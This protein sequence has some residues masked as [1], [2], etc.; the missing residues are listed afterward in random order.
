MC[1]GPK[2]LSGLV[3]LG[4]RMDPRIFSVDYEFVYLLKKEENYGRRF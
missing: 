4:S 3:G 2:G 1:L